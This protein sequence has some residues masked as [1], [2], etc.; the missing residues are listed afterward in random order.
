MIKAKHDQEIEDFIFFIEQSLSLLAIEK[1][2]D[3]PAMYDSSR[4][5]REGLLLAQQP[6]PYFRTI[7]DTYL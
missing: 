5:S 3:F 6:L 1:Y 7:K 4:I 2:E